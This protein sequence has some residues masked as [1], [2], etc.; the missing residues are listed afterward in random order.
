MRRK[1]VMRLGTVLC[2]I[3]SALATLMSF[4]P[5]RTFAS[6]GDIKEWGEFRRSCTQVTL[7][8]MQKFASA[9]VAQAE[10]SFSAA[11][12]IYSELLVRYPGNE[13]I[14]YNMRLM[15]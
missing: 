11:R 13:V 9:T 6:P 1:W 14:T 5:G 3:L 10:G 8:D 4:L 15:E 12:Q 2:G 7:E